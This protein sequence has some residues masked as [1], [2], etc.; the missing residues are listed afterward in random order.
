MSHN[1]VLASQVAC[2]ISTCS[3]ALTVLLL[4]TKVL[5][6][7]LYTIARESSNTRAGKGSHSVGANCKLVTIVCVYCAL[8]D[9]LKKKLYNPCTI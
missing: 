8:I 4:S 2:K 3:K 5:T 9:I 6:I 7:T 1:A